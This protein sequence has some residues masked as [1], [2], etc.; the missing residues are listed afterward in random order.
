MVG[1]HVPLKFVWYA[2]G[3]EMLVRGLHW[4]SVSIHPL[5]Q[6]SSPAE[7]GLICAFMNPKDHMDMGLGLPFWAPECWSENERDTQEGD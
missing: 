6:H 7:M 5:G 3:N 1:T 4:I 2:L